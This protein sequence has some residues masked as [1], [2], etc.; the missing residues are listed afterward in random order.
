MT[1][2]KQIV[3]RRSSQR[4]THISAMENTQSNLPIT[5]QLFRSAVAVIGI[6][7]ESIRRD[8]QQSHSP[9]QTKLSFSLSLSSCQPHLL[10][11]QSQLLKMCSVSSGSSLSESVKSWTKGLISEW[12]IDRDPLTG[13]WVLITEGDT[14]LRYQTD[15]WVL[16]ANITPLYPHS[17]TIP[18]SFLSSQANKLLSQPCRFDSVKK[19]LFHGFMVLFWH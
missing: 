17:H 8:K 7:R 1:G 18:Y 9:T 6:Q 4:S 12:K 2:T 19:P 11:L 16:C 14:R 13:P 10:Q 5:A 15:P 3:S